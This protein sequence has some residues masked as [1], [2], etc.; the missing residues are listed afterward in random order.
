MALDAMKIRDQC[1]CETPHM[2]SPAGQVHTWSN[3]TATGAYGEWAKMAMLLDYIAAELP[4][5]PHKGL[6]SYENPT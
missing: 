5:E 3:L 1:L 6:S 4:G 2:S